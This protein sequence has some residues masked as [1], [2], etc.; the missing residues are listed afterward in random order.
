MPSV[1]PTTQPSI[2][3][4]IPA[5][6]PPLL[7]SW[8][9]ATGMVCIHLSVRVFTSLPDPFTVFLIQAV[10]GWSKRKQQVNQPQC[11]LLRPHASYKRCASLSLVP[12]A[13]YPSSFP[14]CLLARVTPILNYSRPLRVLPPPLTKKRAHCFFCQKPAGP[15]VFVTP[16]AYKRLP[17]LTQRAGA[18]SQTESQT[19]RKT[20]LK[21]FLT[22]LPRLHY[23]ARGAEENR[24]P[25]RRPMDGFPSRLHHLDCVPVDSSAPPT[26]IVQM[27]GTP[28]TPPFERWKGNSFS[29]RR[30]REN[31]L[32][33][34]PPLVSSQAVL[35]ALNLRGGGF[36]P[37][38]RRL[39]R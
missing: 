3:A 15:P 30:P 17:S 33:R 9:H 5:C 26:L 4:S 10:H 20:H 18:L 37:G 25:R 24:Y 1:Q 27:K 29:P 8:V 14:C 31:F 11:L 38:T 34:S 22:A 36:A 19:L 21:P 7:F 35:S 12:L 23:P 6:P 2:R 32:H 28:Y 13:P 39:E 16:V